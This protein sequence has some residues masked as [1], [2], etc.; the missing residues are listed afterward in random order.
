M[1]RLLL[2][3]LCACLISP[4]VA[5]LPA[6]QVWL[7]HLQQDLLPFWTLPDALG[8][9]PGNFP[10][11]RCNNGHAA[12]PE[13]PCP[14]LV[15]RPNWMEGSIDRQ[16]PRMQGRQTYAYALAY[17]LTGNPEYLADA[18]AGANW[19]R[20]NWLDAQGD[21]PSYVEYGRPD[22]GATVRTAQDLAYAEVGMSMLYYVDRDPALLRDIEKLKQ[23]IFSNFR[24]ADGSHLTWL[25]ASAD[26][27]RQE[28]V[29]Q[30]DQINAY[31]LLLTPIVPEPL[32][33][34]WLH[35][36]RWLTNIVRQQYY[37][38]DSGK[39]MGL[40]GAEGKTPG[41]W[42]NDYGHTIKSF[43]MLERAG[44]V[45]NDPELV[46]W[47]REHGAKVLQ[48]AYVTDTGSWAR[49]WKDN[50]ERDL[51]NDW[52]IYCEL[53]QMTATLALD[54]PQYRTL[55]EHTYPYWLEHFVDHHNHEVW[56]SVHA[57]GSPS[58]G[59]KIHLWKNGFH[60]FEHTL[61]AY[62]TTQGMAGQPITLYYAYPPQ[63]APKVLQPYLFHGK[64]LKSSS[65]ALPGRGR[66]E[67]VEFQ[68]Q[69]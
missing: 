37:D 33:S 13:R 1:T 31:M 63:H 9:P 5:D 46:A 45:L 23:H 6:S 47:A 52:W 49:R 20:Q 59:L 21:V 56:G 25:A 24:S 26:N 27:G 57:D 32:H 34:E 16:Y 4:A 15:Q 53:D 42:H 55:L 50:G 19:L 17:H 60:Q 54:D 12:N 8:T 38:P 18:R 29:S 35:D 7:D 68:L 3:L 48:E 30:L 36:L 58:T 11:Y 10:T 67:K 14:E 69:E 61:V 65:F 62:I 22:A 64:V 43:W 28:L 66:G 39:F 44:H 41:G 51:G 40:I 2:I